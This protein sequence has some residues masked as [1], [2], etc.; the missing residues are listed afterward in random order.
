MLA[1]HGVDISVEI[2]ELDYFAA[3][4]RQSDEAGTT[5]VQVQVLY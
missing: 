5:D 1:T 2:Y 4:S 3:L